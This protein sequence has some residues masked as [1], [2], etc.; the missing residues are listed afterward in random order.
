MSLKGRGRRDRR[1]QDHLAQRVIKFSFLRNTGAEGGNKANFL[2]GG[3][4][5]LESTGGAEIAF[6]D[7]GASE[8]YAR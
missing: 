4:M 8:T 3:E 7:S 1:L 5:R 2:V 6:P